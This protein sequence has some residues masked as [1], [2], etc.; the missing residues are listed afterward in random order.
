[1]R[2]TVHRA[3]QTNFADHSANRPTKQHVKASP[4]LQSHESEAGTLDHSA[5]HRPLTVAK[6]HYL[7]ALDKSKVSDSHVL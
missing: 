1:M 7:R 5:K 4:S 6:S 3:T 2:R